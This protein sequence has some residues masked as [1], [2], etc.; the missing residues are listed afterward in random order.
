MKGQAFS[1][2]EVA[3]TFVLEMWARMDSGQLFS[4]FNE[5]MERFEYI[6]ESGGGY[7]I[8]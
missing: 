3:K 6:I 1:N 2:R 5:W 7:C 4:G 8:K